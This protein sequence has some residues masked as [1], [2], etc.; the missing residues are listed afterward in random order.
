M[1]NPAA[2][3]QV[4]NV[5][6]GQPVSVLQV[7]SLLAQD[8]GWV[9]KFEIQ[10]KFRAGDI[11]HCFADIR[12]IRD[13]LGYEPRYR[14]EEGVHELVAWVRQQQALPGSSSEANQQLA[15]YGLVR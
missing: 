1:T 2:D 4:F 6:S 13:S 8:L 3:Y 15:S 5:G 14:F 9:G 7:A 10:N 12:R 11:R